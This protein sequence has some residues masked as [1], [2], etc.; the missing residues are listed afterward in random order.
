M[1]D[2]TILVGERGT[3]VRRG[4]D[5]VLAIN[6]DLLA[7]IVLNS[8]TS[9]GGT[10]LADLDVSGRRVGSSTNVDRCAGSCGINTF[11]DG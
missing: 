10:V 7:V 9:G 6:D 11:L 4:T 2:T 3:E 8:V 1:E 5:Q